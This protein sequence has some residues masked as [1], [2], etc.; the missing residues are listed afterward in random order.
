MFKFSS[1]RIY[2]TPNKSICSVAFI[3]W[4]MESNQPFQIVNDP[5]FRM[6]MKTG[7]PDCYIPSAETLS[8]DVKNIFVC[9]HAC[10]AKMLEVKSVHTFHRKIRIYLPGTTEV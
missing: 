5:S 6:L 1:L 10:I 2:S 8:C 7:R 9:I 3:S 4:V